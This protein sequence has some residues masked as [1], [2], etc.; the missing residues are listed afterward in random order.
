MSFYTGRE[1]SL[2]IGSNTLVKVRD[3]TL[4]TTV[5]LLSVNTIDSF[6]NEF[7]PGVKGATGTA[8]LIYYTKVGSFN[9]QNLLGKL[10]KQGAIDQDDDVNELTLKV[11]KDASIIANVFITSAS[12]AVSNNELTVVSTNFTVNGD[13]LAAP[14]F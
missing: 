13:F 6:A 2:K 9:F 14:Q 10:L 1:G 7:T 8:T 12:L 11:H 3:W 5:E 4:E